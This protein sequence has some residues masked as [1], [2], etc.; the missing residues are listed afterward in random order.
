MSYY[1]FLQY[2]LILWRQ[3]SIFTKTCRH[4]KCIRLQYDSVTES[5]HHDIHPLFSAFKRF[6][7]LP[8]IAILH[9]NDGTVGHRQT[10]VSVCVCV[11]VLK[12]HWAKNQYFFIFY[13]VWFRYWWNWHH[14][15]VFNIKFLL[16]ACLGVFYLVIQ[17]LW[18]IMDVC[19]TMNPVLQDR[20]FPIPLLSW[21]NMLWF[22]VI[23]TL[24]RTGVTWMANATSDNPYFCEWFPHEITAIPHYTT[25]HS[26]LYFTVAA[27]SITQTY[28]SIF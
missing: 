14:I 23:P 25:T 6:G 18:C 28:L 12:R 26:L 17:T 24:C 27:V 19:L 11:C 2:L 10:A 22:T 21:G 16:Y 15:A 5:R 20:C 3:I 9:C 4:S 1:F 8:F 13:I 7:I